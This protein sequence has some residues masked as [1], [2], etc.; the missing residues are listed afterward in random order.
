MLVFAREYALRLSR[1]TVPA[2]RL[3]VQ[4]RNDG[5]DAHD[6]ALRTPAGRLVGRMPEV[7]PATVGMLRV[8]LRPGRYVMWC[9]LPGH[10]DMGMRASFRVTH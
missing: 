9:T 10:E 3:V 1:R 6:L 7:R 4:M 8:R 2:G 5:E